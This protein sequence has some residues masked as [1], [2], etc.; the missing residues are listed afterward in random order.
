MKSKIFMKSMGVISS[1]MLGFSILPATAQAEGITPRSLPTAP[2]ITFDADEVD[3]GEKIGVTVTFADTMNREVPFTIELTENAELAQDISVDDITFKTNNKI[4]PMSSVT[5]HDDFNGMDVLTGKCVKNKMSSFQFTVEAPVAATSFQVILKTDSSNEMLKTIT[6]EKIPILSGLTIEAPDILNDV[7][8]FDVTG[9]AKYKHQ[10]VPE[11]THMYL[12]I[13]NQDP[14]KPDFHEIQLLTKVVNDEY[15]FSSIKLPSDYED[16]A[17]IIK[18]YLW[19]DEHYKLIGYAEKTVQFIASEVS[20]TIEAPDILNDVDEFDVTGR[21]RCK[22]GALPEN[23]HMFMEIVNQDPDKPYFFEVQLL[24]P[25]INNEYKFPSIKLPSDY[26]DG[27]YTINVYLWDDD[28]FEL[29]GS[30]EKN[31]KF[32]KKA[33]QPEPESNADTKTE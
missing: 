3:G 24:E 27:D 32:I 8:L 7:D 16:G 28:K 29:I 30:A 21:A 12:E 31:V 33:V 19:D 9:T 18:V 13:V 10:S 25:I 5:L 6:S 17:Y 22:L 1:L 26:E 20:L 23:I 2:V 4:V 15:C 11:N 14:E